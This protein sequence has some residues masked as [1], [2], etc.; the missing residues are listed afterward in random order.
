MGGVVYAF[1]FSLLSILW[2]VLNVFESTL[3]WFFK[4]VLTMS[5]F[6]TLFSC[7]HYLGKSKLLQKLGEFSLP[8]YLIHPFLC[9]LI[10]PQILKFSL[11]NDLVN[12]IILLLTQIAIVSITYGIVSLVFKIKV[13]KR[14]LFPGSYKELMNIY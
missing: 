4:P 10:S 14:F 3:Y 7:R 8:I 12:F 11:T 9:I 2:F 6:L 1:I 5:F 13:I